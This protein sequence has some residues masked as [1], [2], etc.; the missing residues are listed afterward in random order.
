MSKCL[1]DFNDLYYWREC[2]GYKRWER[3]PS[4]REVCYVNSA[5][6]HAAR[7]DYC[8]KQGGYLL[9]ITTAEDAQALVGFVWNLTR[10]ASRSTSS[11]ATGG[12]L[13]KFI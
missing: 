2:L 1:Q 8:E 4:G 11:I 7:K 12:R 6:N 9:E 5:K 10:D 3:L 13:D